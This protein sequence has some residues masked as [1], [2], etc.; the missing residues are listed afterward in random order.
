M[1]FIGNREQKKHIWYCKKK[2]FL[3]TSKAHHLFD[4]LI[5]IAIRLVSHSFGFTVHKEKTATNTD[6]QTG[7]SKLPLTGIKLPTR[8][9]ID[10]SWPPAM[11][12][13][14]VTPQVE[15]SNKTH[16]QYLIVYL[17]SRNLQFFFTKMWQKM[18]Q[19]KHHYL[20][21]SFSRAESKGSGSVVPYCH[22]EK[23]E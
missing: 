19:N 22:S 12:I 9:L 21:L 16:K 23:M 3:A 8:Q 14:P 11:G 2:H 1:Q 13:K 18:M 4:S 15:W 20:G 6:W 5:L 10:Y 17:I 7:Y